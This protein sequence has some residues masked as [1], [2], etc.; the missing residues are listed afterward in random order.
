MLLVEDEDIVRSLTRLV[1]QKNGY[2][3]LEAGSG[4]EALRLCEQFTGPIHLMVTD[5]MMPKMTGRQLAERLAAPRPTMK[6]LYLSG[7]TD[8]AV[9][10]HGAL[11]LDM[12][13]LQ[14]PY[15]TDVL[16]RRVR[17]LLDQ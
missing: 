17:E 8:E 12:P 7:Y 6:V 14:K 3:V 4:A 16:A 10:R 2:H 11:D 1:L 13:F 15:S 5:V 9:V